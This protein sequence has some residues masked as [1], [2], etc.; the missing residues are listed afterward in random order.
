MTC[1]SCNSH[2]ITVKKGNK[3][4]AECSYCGKPSDYYISIDY[5]ED[6]DEEDE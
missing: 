6:Y 1:D 4:V 3:Y 2:V 5:A